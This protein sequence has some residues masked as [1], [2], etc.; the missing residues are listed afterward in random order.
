MRIARD[1]NFTNVVKDLL[2]Y[3]VDTTISG[4][5]PATTYYLDVRSENTAGN[6][7]WSTPTTFTTKSIVVLPG[8]TTIT[9]PNNT[10][11]KVFTP[12]QFNYST[13]DATSWHMQFSENSSFTPL[14]KDT[15]V[16]NNHPIIPLNNGKHMYA[17]IHGING[18]GDGPVSNVEFTTIKKIPTTPI[19]KTPSNTAVEVPQNVSFSWDPVT[20]AESYNVIIFDHDENMILDTT[21]TAT[22]FTK[23]FPGNREFRWA[24]QSKNSDVDG[25]WSN[26]FT[27]TTFNNAPTV[28]RVKPISTDLI[29]HRDNIQFDYMASDIDKDVLFN[30]LFIRGGG[31]D[32]TISNITN[33]YILTPG[34][35]KNNTS[36]EYSIKSSDGKKSSTTSTGTFNTIN[37]GIE[38]KIINS[39]KVYPN[40]TMDYIKVNMTPKPNATITIEVYD[41]RGRLIEHFIDKNVNE[42]NQNI[43]MRKYPAGMYIL[44]IQENNKPVDRIKVL[45]Q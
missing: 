1:A 38:E 21:M 2:V 23:Y 41:G 15:T 24:V 3:R 43:D 32:T 14:V 27:Y 28:S 40:P 13:P 25:P 29:D 10:A 35:L 42:Y 44:N 6:S 11:T 31:K 9:T 17:R 39:L 30:E 37:V 5:D 18:S 20:Y 36:Y 16:N 45:K 7:G 22:E 8:T 12:V 4:L 26:N 34:F 33:P 19:L